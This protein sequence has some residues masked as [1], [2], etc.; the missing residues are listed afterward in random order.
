MTASFVLVIQS[1]FAISFQRHKKVLLQVMLDELHIVCRGIPCVIDHV[2]KANL[3]MRNYLQKHPI[4][5][6]LSDLRATLLLLGFMINK[7]FSLCDQIKSERQT[8]KAS[9]IQRGKEVDPFD[10]ALGRVI[11]MPTDE[12]VFVCVGFLFDAV[13][14]NQYGVILFNLSKQGLN[15]S[16]QLGTGLFGRGQKSSDLI[17]TNFSIQQP[18]QAGGGCLAK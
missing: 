10:V 2:A 12:I 16:P 18:R 15:N 3:V 9:H 7:S 14:D 17:V 1:H 8:D 5:S 6:V 11:P 13:I 4:P